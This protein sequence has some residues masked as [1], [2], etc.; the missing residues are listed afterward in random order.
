[1]GNATQGAARHALRLTDTGLQQLRSHA[2]AA[3]LRP[4]SAF[5]WGGMAAN[6]LSA[7]VLVL[8]GRQEATAS[9]PLNAVSHWAFGDKSLRQNNPSARYT[10]TGAAIHAG[11]SLFWSLLY[12]AAL[13][14]PL[15]R[16]RR[17]DDDQ[18]HAAAPLVAGAAVVAA[19]AAAVDLKLVPERLTPGFQHRLS[20]SSLVMT[21]A[22][23][24]IGLAVGGLLQLRG[25]D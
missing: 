10:A 16:R 19:V 17:D 5:W 25:R 3:T 7:G 8:R 9:A 15:R 12:D 23:F 1:M 22:T 20:A 18:L 11:S 13:V 24:G 4:S 2:A 14:K 21:Y 6:L